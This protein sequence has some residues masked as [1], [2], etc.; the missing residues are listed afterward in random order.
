MGKKKKS[1]TEEFVE[2]VQEVYEYRNQHI[3]NIAG[4]LEA[5]AWDA[6]KAYYENPQ[7]AQ[8]LTDGELSFLR[9]VVS[10]NSDE[11]NLLN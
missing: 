7:L 4:L 5:K 1:L 3:E 11:P 8:F 2:L 10:K 6:V 9:A